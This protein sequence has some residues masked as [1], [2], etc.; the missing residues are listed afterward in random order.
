MKQYLPLILAAVLSFLLVAWILGR[1]GASGGEDDVGRGRT[2]R[3]GS[4]SKLQSRDPRLEGESEGAARR[5]RPATRHREPL[6]VEAGAEA[7]TTGAILVVGRIAGLAPPELEVAILAPGGGEVGRSEPR[8]EGTLVLDLEPGRYSVRA[9][10]GDIVPVIEHGVEVVAGQRTVLPL[11]LERGMRFAGRVMH[12]DQKRVIPFA[13][14]EFV[15]FTAI[16][17]DSEGWFDT[18]RLFSRR[19]LTKVRVSADGWDAIEYLQHQV[20]DP[21]DMRLYLGGGEATVRCRIENTTAVPLPE[22]ARI[23]LTIPPHEAV[24]RD[25]ATGG[26]SLVEIPNLYPSLYRFELRLPDG[27]TS[28]RF[29]EARIESGPGVT[30]VVFELRP[31]ATLQGRFLGPA[32]VVGASRLELRQQRN[33]VVARV[34][35]DSEGNFRLRD[36]PAGRYS[37]YVVDGAGER[38]VGPLELSGDEVLERDVDVLRKTLVPREN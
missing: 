1:S 2:A 11:D 35:P 3:S 37:V 21:T 25:V 18:G 22:N 28:S 31:G 36:L 19:A 27:D 29:V 4:D 33:E 5:D 23:V 34:G 17:T 20:P 7:A 8:E 15:G 13:R 30:E 24:R 6:D 26:R 9:R 12:A 32:A 16:T 10:G 38:P 14:V